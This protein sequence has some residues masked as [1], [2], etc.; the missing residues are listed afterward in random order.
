D[1]DAWVIWDPFLADAQLATKARTIVDGTS[2]VENREF[3]LAAKPF[4]QNHADVLQ[5]IFKQLEK[6]DLWV[7]KNPK[8]AAEFLAP[9]IGMDK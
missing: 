6:T 4:A 9:Q 2:L 7:E 1:V 8:Q 5:V 3:F